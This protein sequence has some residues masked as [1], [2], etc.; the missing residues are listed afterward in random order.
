MMERETEELSAKRRRVESGESDGGAASSTPGPGSS[1][2]HESLSVDETNAL[3]MKL[4][5]SPL[6][7][8]K[9]KKEGE[10]EAGKKKEE[11]GDFHESLS[12]DDTNALREKLGLK[13]LRTGK[14]KSDKGGEATGGEEDVEKTAKGEVFALQRVKEECEYATRDLR[15]DKRIGVG[16]VR[17]KSQWD[18]RFLEK[19][20]GLEH[21][22]G[23]APKRFANDRGG[24]DN[25]VEPDFEKR[26]WNTHLSVA[27][28][29]ALRSRLGLSPLK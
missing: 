12:V 22:P 24:S 26:R 16:K 2:F 20:H 25:F 14:K 29:D 7:V 21:K 9:P 8:A 1:D 4:G 13:P 17:A 28:S 3:R 19:G 18:T 11:D 10:G 23:A 5:L 6:R 27:A 15:I